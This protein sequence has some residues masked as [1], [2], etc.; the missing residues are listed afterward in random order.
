LIVNPGAR[1]KN[2]N[3]ATIVEE[4]LDSVPV[5]GTRFARPRR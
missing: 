2:T 3:T 5:P 1:V 4:I